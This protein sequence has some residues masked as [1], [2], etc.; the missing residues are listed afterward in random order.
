MKERDLKNEYG[1]W[2]AHPQFTVDDWV[3]EVRN[4]D[5]RSGYWTWVK[6][7]LDLVK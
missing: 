6:A 1:Y 5:T 7:K 3:Y 2:G 4:G